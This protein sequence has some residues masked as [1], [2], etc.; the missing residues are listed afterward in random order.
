MLVMREVVDAL[1]YCGMRVASIAEVPERA[2]VFRVG[3]RRP[4]HLQIYER[5]WRISSA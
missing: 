5:R 3:F 4:P 2:V 1:I